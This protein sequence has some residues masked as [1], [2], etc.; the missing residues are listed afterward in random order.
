MNDEI[1]LLVDGEVSAK[2]ASRL[3]ERLVTDEDLRQ[4]WRTYL[5]IGNALRQHLNCSYDM[6]DKITR[7]IMH[8]PTVL[9]PRRS[10]FR[11][12]FLYLSAAASLLMFVTGTWVVLGGSPFTASTSLSGALPSAA[13]NASADISPYLLAHEEFSPTSAIQGDEAYVRSVS[14]RTGTTR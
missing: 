5:L 12:P 6:T 1:S 9:S 10:R 11:Q 13:A 2:S 14:F 8:E 3:I 7:Q 4:E